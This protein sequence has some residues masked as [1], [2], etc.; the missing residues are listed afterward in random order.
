MEKAAVGCHEIHT[1]VHDDAHKTLILAQHFDEKA[2]KVELGIR[3]HLAKKEGLV[4]IKSGI[5]FSSPL[6]DKAK[7][8]NKTPVLYAI[9]AM[10][11]VIE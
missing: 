9:N 5:K 4:V 11:K 2:Q 6:S 10:K 3:W 7:A 1:V 8:D